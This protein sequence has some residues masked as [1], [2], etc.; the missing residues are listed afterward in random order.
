MEQSSPAPPKPLPSYSPATGEAAAR[1]AGA[2][3]GVVVL[4]AGRRE[5]IEEAR[6]QRASVQA[7]APG[8]EESELHFC[9]AGGAPPA[10]PALLLE[11]PGEAP[12]P[13]PA[14]PSPA[15]AA[16]AGSGAARGA[17]GALPAPGCLFKFGEVGPIPSKGAWGF[18]VNPWQASQHSPLP[19]GGTGSAPGTRAQAAPA[20]ARGQT[21]APSFPGSP[22]AP[23]GEPPALGCLKKAAPTEPGWCLLPQRGNGVTQ[24]MC[25]T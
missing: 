25:E 5:L 19:R 4:Q 18:G 21:A 13:A 20:R 3:L 17:Q 12:L 2:L 8:Q 14:R 11:G 10:L 6:S 23:S 7:A 22:R 24:V 16:R 9:T 1:R 15:A